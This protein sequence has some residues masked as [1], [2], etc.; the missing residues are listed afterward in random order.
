MGVDSD[1]INAE[2]SLHCSPNCGAIVV[3]D[4]SGRISMGIFAIICNRIYNED[5]KKRIE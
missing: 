5:Y 2:L 4:A 1:A 3:R